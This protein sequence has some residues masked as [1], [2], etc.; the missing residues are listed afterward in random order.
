MNGMYTAAG[1]FDV[2]VPEFRQLKACRREVGTNIV[3]HAES[4]PQ[5]GRN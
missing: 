3:L 1:L 2:N 4:L 5:G